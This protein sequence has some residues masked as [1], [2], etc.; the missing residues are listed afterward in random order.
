MFTRVRFT[1]PE[2]NRCVE[3]RGI[4][5]HTDVSA[6]ILRAQRLDGE[7]GVDFSNDLGGVAAGEVGIL[8]DVS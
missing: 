8:K 7:V 1:A 6:E 5:L 4:A 3:Q 2:G